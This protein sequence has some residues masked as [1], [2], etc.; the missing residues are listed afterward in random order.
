MCLSDR[1]RQRS[2]GR[3][4]SRS[5]DA[6]LEDAAEVLRVGGDKSANVD[7]QLLLQDCL[8]RIKRKTPVVEDALYVVRRHRFVYHFLILAPHTDRQLP[9]THAII[10]LRL[11]FI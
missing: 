1:Y 6:D 3:R 10:R 11:T 4:Q 8:D 9:S 2:V 7:D 5:P